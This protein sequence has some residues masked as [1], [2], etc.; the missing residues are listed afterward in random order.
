MARPSSREKILDAAQHLLLAHGPAG[1]V[2]DAVAEE[3]GVSKGGLLYHFASKEALAE[4]LTDRMGSFFD[5]AQ[6]QIGRADPVAS[7]RHT[8][9]YL[10]S[11]VGEDGKP[12][13]GSARLMAGILA[14]LGSDPARLHALRERFSAWHARLD[15]DGIDPVNATLVRL[16]ADGLW[17]SELLGLAPLS[18]ERA[19]QVVAALDALTREPSP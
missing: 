16:A 5:L 4:G 11:T 9:A 18:P 2:L 7:G 19:R 10:G 1:L 17:L 8:R 3:A 14:A 13:D 6:Q 15:G 12:A